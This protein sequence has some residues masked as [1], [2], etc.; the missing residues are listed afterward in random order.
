MNIMKR[1]NDGGEY[2]KRYIFIIEVIEGAEWLHIQLDDDYTYSDEDTPEPLRELKISLKPFDNAAGL[3]T[4]YAGEVDAD[5]YELKKCIRELIELATSEGGKS[6][7]LERFSLE[8]YKY[9]T[10][11]NSYF[12]KI[13]F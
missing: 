12:K 10:I 13:I 11:L 4:Y 8:P 3:T 7:S 2:Y 1:A 9:Y 6:I 5:G